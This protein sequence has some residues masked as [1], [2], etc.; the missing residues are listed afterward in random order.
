[1]P[2]KYRKLEKLPPRQQEGAYLNELDHNSAWYKIRVLLKEQ[3]G[4]SVD[5]AWFS[6]LIAEE[7]INTKEITLIAPTNF[8]KDY[9]R[10]NYQYKIQLLVRELGYYMV[11]LMCKDQVQQVA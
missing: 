4:A 1:M 9:I 5:K 3:F 10:N 11:E 7:N 8:I 2:N 6:K